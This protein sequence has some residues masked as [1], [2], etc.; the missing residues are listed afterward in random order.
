MYPFKGTQSRSNDNTSIYAEAT[1]IPTSPSP[2]VTKVI[3]E[4]VF[5]AMFDRSKEQFYKQHEELVNIKSE[6]LRLS[7]D[8]KVLK[9]TTTKF[10][11]RHI[12]QGKHISSLNSSFE[13]LLKKTIFRNR[14]GRNIEAAE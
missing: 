12:E 3:L 1:N 10:L 2:S 5:Q 7:E 9:E 6:T 4:T 14:V 8:T 13:E 11:S